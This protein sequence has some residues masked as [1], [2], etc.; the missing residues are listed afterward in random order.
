MRQ[1]GGIE[2]FCEVVR[3]VRSKNGGFNGFRFDPEIGDE[4]V[5]KVRAYAE[6]YER[7]KLR[8]LR[9]EVREWVDGLV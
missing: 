3:C 4:A 7:D 1:I 2:P 5:L 8:S 9:S 6:T